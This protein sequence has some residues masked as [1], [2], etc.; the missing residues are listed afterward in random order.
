M[1]EPR[2]AGAALL[3]PRMLLR[4]AAWFYLG[5]GL[6]TLVTLPLPAPRGTD[7]LV[8]VAVAVAAM[9]VGAATI[10]VPWDRWP[11]R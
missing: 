7:R 3:Q 6:I 11:W 4:V 10:V 2:N 1:D 8:L 9:A 5:S